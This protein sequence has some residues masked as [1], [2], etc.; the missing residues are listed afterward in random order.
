[1]IS[2]DASSDFDVKKLNK[3]LKN[4]RTANISEIIVNVN[5][6]N[7]GTVAHLEQLHSRC[8]GELITVIAADEAYA[9]EFAIERLVKEYL[10]HDKKVGVITSLLAMC[11]E[12]LSDIKS[13]FTSDKDVELINSGDTSRLFEELSYRCIMPSSGT[14]ITPAVLSQIG[15]LQPDYKYVDD[16]SSQLRMARMNIQI[17]CIK[18]VTV[19]H[20]GGGL[21][22]NTSAD[23]NVYL[24]YNRDLLTVYEKEIEPYISQLSGAA[25]KRAAH[26]YNERCAK[27]KQDLDN[28]ALKSDKQKVVFFFRKGILAKG[29]FALYYRIAEY[30][31]N[32]TDYEIY[33][34]NN[35]YAEIQ[36]NYLNSG[37]H[38]CDIKPDN[39]HYF[40]NATFILGYNQLFFLLEEIGDLKNAKLLLLFLHPQ[41]YKWMKSQVSPRFNHNSV[42]K[43]LKQNN[44][45]GFMD[46][47]NLLAVQK[48]SAVKFEKRY[49]P[50]VL[51]KIENEW[52]SLPIINQNEINIA[53]FGRLDGDKINSC[54]NFLDNL[55]DFEFGKPITVHLVGDGNAK[56]R[57]NLKKYSPQMRF[58]FNSY[59]YGEDKDNYLRE[60]ADLVVAMGICALNAAALKLPTV[61]PIVS[62]SHIKSNKFIL[63]NDT[64]DYCLGTN[65]EDV[66]D[67]GCKTYT[68]SDVIDLIY[69]ADNKRTIGEE[70]YNCACDNF[71]LEAQAQKY[72]DLI[73]NTTLTVKKCKKNPSI[74]GQLRFFHLYRTI[75]KNRNY[76]AFLLFRQKLNGLASL[77]T[78]G[79]L[80]KLLIYVK[81]K[82]NR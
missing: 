2:D 40:E 5:S 1:I 49:F 78:K 75:N 3:Y 51:D 8:K 76:A 72:I 22:G 25:A 55:I 56:E 26:C 33:C 23:N 71:S 66:S 50:V 52:Q 70:C 59:M 57:I 6:K 42:F 7:M 81:E 80:K 32:N 61:L 4:H 73:K 41:I 30:M 35:S 44:A 36:K 28:E 65:E 27:Y 62:T 10:R 53:W 69:S 14:A 15:S 21:L 58:V 43:M 37:I 67:L 16:W 24:Q 63:F 19:L 20:R 38:F 39:L 46:K 34:V 13:I 17:R 31:V 18:H 54:L 68:A 12:E 64:K 77:T 79:K 9:D 11:G 47:S 82:I 29:D 48:H 60:N 74:A 45:Y